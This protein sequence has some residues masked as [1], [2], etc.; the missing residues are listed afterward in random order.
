MS[1][2]YGF[3]LGERD[4]VE[5]VSPRFVRVELNALIDEIKELTDAIPWD[6]DTLRHHR[7]SFPIKA[8]A[9]PPDEARFLSRLF[10]YHVDRVLNRPLS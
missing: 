8:K 10:E 1:T 9:L 6:A 5:P 2:Q 3:D 7:T 4:P